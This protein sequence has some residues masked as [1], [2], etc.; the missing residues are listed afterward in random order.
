[1][2]PNPIARSTPKAPPTTVLAQ[3]G[4]FTNDLFFSTH[5]STPRNHTANMAVAPIT[6]MLKKRLLF[7]IGAG[8]GL[9]FAGGYAFWYGVHV[10]MMKKRDNYYAKLDAKKYGKD[11]VPTDI[12][13]ESVKN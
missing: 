3:A 6:G 10:P 7:D 13:Q 12:L 9:G 1:M 5:H 11:A 8:L 4:P 2:S